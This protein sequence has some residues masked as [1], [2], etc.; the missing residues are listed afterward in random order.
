MMKL[1]TIYQQHILISPCAKRNDSSGVLILSSRGGHRSNKEPG[2]SP[3]TILAREKEP[4]LISRVLLKLCG[5]EL[6]IIIRVY[7]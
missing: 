2:F 4:A 3:A 6:K 5:R 7:S 1:M